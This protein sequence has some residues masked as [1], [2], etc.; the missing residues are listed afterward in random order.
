MELRLTI[1]V[2]EDGSFHIH[3]EDVPGLEISNAH[4]E[5]ALRDL[6]PAIRRLVPEFPPAARAYCIECEKDIG[7]YDAAFP[8]LV[9]MSCSFGE[10]SH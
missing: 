7:E 3:S 2:Q 6:L 4:A 5:L 10:L 1:S 9:C 8:H